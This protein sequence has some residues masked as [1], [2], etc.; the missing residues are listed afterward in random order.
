MYGSSFF[1]N[2]IKQQFIFPLTDHLIS[3]HAISR[4]NYF[5]IEKKQHPLLV[6]ERD[7]L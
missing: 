3:S 7:V 5:S 6:N 2:E 1:L 4:H